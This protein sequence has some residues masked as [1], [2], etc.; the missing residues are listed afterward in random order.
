MSDLFKNMDGFFEK[1]KPF[2]GKHGIE[3]ISF[4]ATPEGV[5]RVIVNIA[6]EEGVSEVS[7]PTDVMDAIKE[8]FPEA[9]IEC[10]P[11][12]P[13]QALKDAARKAR[14]AELEAMADSMDI[15]SLR[16]HFVADTMN[17]ENLQE[18]YSRALSKIGILNDW[19][20]AQQVKQ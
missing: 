14:Q 7:L 16:A 5:P 18:N 4:G 19:L 13:R 10:V 11:Y 2:I 8:T 9:Y 17:Y 6:C 20:K 3:I 15:E 12:P 1:I